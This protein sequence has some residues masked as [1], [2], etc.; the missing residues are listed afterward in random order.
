LKFADYANS[1]VQTSGLGCF[2]RKTRIEKEKFQTAKI[3]ISANTG[4]IGR[5][6]SLKNAGKSPIYGVKPFWHLHLSQTART[7]YFIAPA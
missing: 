5:Q 3:A 7:V 4:I 6:L 2:R 1:Q